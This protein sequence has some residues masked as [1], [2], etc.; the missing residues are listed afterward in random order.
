M[1]AGDVGT[2][3]GGASGA[4]DA[5]CGSIEGDVVTNPGGAPGGAINGDSLSTGSGN[6]VAGPAGIGEVGTKPLGIPGI[7]AGEGGS[8]TCGTGT[9]GMGAGSGTE[10]SICAL[11]DGVL[12]GLTTC[13]F[14][15]AFGF[16]RDCEDSKCD[17]YK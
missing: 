7:F 10:E 1:T 16:D 12:L 11:R 4:N 14:G 6:G 8:G 3:P 13:G 2:N 15:M 17:Y 5:P 9:C